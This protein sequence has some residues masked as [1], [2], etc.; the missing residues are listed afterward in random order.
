MNFDIS[1][2]REQPE[3]FD[4]I[5]DRIW[6]KWWEPKGHPLGSIVD[7]L[8]ENLDSPGIP[9]ALVAHRDGKFF[10]TA[11]LIASDLDER[12]QYSPWV[13]AVWTEAH[14]R[15]QGIGKAL[16]ARARH[17]AFRLGHDPVYLCA[18]PAMHPFYLGLGWQPIERDVGP[19]HVTV[20]KSCRAA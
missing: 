10:G 9:V 8:R 5:A 3:F 15:G 12:P 13:A 14:A 19:L 11:S 16:V 1:D 20:F 18:R 6:R 4:T 17:E 2:L 7:R